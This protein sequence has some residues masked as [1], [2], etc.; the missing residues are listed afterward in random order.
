MIGPPAKRLFNCITFAGRAKDDQTWNTGLVAL[1]FSWGFGPVLLRNPIFFM[2][3]P[4]WEGPDPLPP[5]SGYAHHAFQVHY[6]S[7]ATYFYRDYSLRTADSSG[8]LKVHRA[9]SEQPDQEHCNMLTDRRD[10]TEKR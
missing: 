1:R 5:P 2:I 10:M 6:F 7:Q 4:E 9:A 3:C 8:A